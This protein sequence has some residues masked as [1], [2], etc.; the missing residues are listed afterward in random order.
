VHGK[1]TDNAKAESFD[2]GFRQEC[3]NAHWF[4]SL[5]DARSKIEARRQHYNETRPYPALG[6]AKPAEF[7]RQSRKIA[8]PNVPT[9]SKFPTRKWDGFW[10]TVTSFLAAKNETSLISGRPERGGLFTKKNGLPI[11][12][13]SI[14]E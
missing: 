8:R 4:L 2:G 14:N 9:E 3:L 13:Y 7:A 10:G 11:R 5:D 12:N 6:W 1:P